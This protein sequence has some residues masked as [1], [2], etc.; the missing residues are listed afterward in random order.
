M[1]LLALL[2][3]LKLLP[4]LASTVQR[5]IELLGAFPRQSYLHVL[6]VQ[7]RGSHDDLCNSWQP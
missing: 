2:D 7:H 1:I 6:L 5:S 4:M 3:L